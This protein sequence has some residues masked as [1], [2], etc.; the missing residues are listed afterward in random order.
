MA[1]EAIMNTEMKSGLPDELRAIGNLAVNH[2]RKT[3]DVEVTDECSLVG[4]RV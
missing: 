1:F 4:C 2:C 3:R